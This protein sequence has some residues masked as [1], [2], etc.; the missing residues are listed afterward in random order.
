VNRFLK[1]W[2]IALAVKVV[3]AIFLPLSNDEAYYWVW[4]HHPH[5]SYFDHPPMIG[6]L[7]AVGT[8]FENFF[9]AA[10]LPG[11]LLAHLTLLIWNQILK[12]YLDEASLA[13]WLIF[14]LFSPFLGIGS[15]IMTPD[16][17]LVFFWSLS[18]W[19]L[20]KTIETHETKW[21]LALGAALG[22]GF[23]S[24]YMIVLFVPA[25]L[26]WLAW[27]GTWRKISLPKTLLTIVT[28]LVFCAP[29][30]YWN[31]QNEW[32]SFAFQIH[33]GLGNEKYRQTWPLEY[34]L[35]QIGLIFPTVLWYAVKRPKNK[36]LR[37]LVCFGWFPIA[38]FL[39]T[40]FKARV[41]ANWPIMAYPALLSLAVINAKDRV[42]LKTTIGIWIV[43]LA[44]VLSEAAYPW[45]P[46]NPRKLKTSEYTRFD[47]VLP[48][49]RDIPNLY[50]GSYQMAAAVSY[51]LRKQYYKLDGMNRR[52]FYDFTPLSHPKGDTFSVAVETDFV[53]PEWLKKEGYEPG[54]SKQITNELTIIEVNRRAKDTDRK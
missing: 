12:P 24:K 41:E 7:F 17:P 26:L 16:I 22:L 31:W 48:V 51:K 33:H 11:V 23:C 14:V 30:L 27:S 53:F 39:Y 1:I 43:A 37:L 21:Y 46:I 50:M 6:W 49:A 3:L 35:A 54:S 5:L 36:D 28:G 19:M 2:W 38:F 4:G 20:L 32:A 25:A 34:L 18:I 10:R 52:D 9:N 42:W 8:I 40:S 44:I 45:I 29:V 47:A 13:F 15:L